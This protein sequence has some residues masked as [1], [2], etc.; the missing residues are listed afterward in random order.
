MGCQDCEE[1]SNWREESR[2][3]VPVHKKQIMNSND[4]NNK[5]NILARKGKGLGVVNQVMNKLEGTV[6]YP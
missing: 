6:F 3:P 4:G 5:K 2:R 1:Y